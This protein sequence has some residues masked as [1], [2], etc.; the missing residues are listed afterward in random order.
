MDNIEQW[1]DVDD[2]SVRF[3]SVHYTTYHYIYSDCFERSY[4]ILVNSML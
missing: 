1:L 3:L 2:V 4:S